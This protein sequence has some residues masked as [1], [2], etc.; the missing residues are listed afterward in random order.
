LRAPISCFSYVLKHIFGESAARKQGIVATAPGG[1]GIY[2]QNTIPLVMSVSGA[3]T[4]ASG[5]IVSDWF[6]ICP[7]ASK[8]I[9]TSSWQGK[10]R[11]CARAFSSNCG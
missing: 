1:K 8:T 4:Q 7:E 5:F 10:K 9:P 3:T 6:A 2:V 11:F